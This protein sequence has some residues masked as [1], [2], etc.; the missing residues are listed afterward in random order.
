MF[1]L[2][3]Q[4]KQYLTD[5]MGKVSR[6]F[7]LVVAQ[8]EEPLNLFLATAYL[9]CRVA[10]NIEDSLRPISWQQQRFNEFGRL[11]QEPALA[12]EI[13]ARWS[14]E[15]W[16]GLSADEQSMMGLG[17][18]ARLWK[19]YGALPGPTQ[20]SIFD[21]VSVMAQGMAQLEGADAPPLTMRLNGIRLLVS[22]Q[23][24]NRYCYFVAGTVGY[25]STELVVAH[26]EIGEGVAQRLYESCEACGRGLQ[27][28][29]IIKDFAEDLQRQVCY[30]PATWL[31]EANY[32]PLALEGAPRSWKQRV[33][34][35]AQRELHQ[36]LD[37]VLT[38]P[39]NAVGYRKASLMC[40]LPGLH[41]LLMAAQKVD[42]LFTSQ[43]YVK[44]SRANMMQCL[45]ESQ[46]IWMDNDAISERCLALEQA[47]TTSL[48]RTPAFPWPDAAPV[49]VA[50]EPQEQVEA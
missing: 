31:K 22:E 49:A 26:Y 7:A 33:I 9:I 19:I 18:G 1:T 11:L 10:D 47:I 12:P 39:T 37:H 14:R 6:S 42:S 27:K 50:P 30:L 21:W 4:D 32:A 36:A 13:L 46:S 43:H 38:L 28:T 24:Y 23:D 41:T 34:Q 5:S 45:L 16:P 15:K 2:A 35:D 17:G 20:Q 3:P 25:L 48:G 8:L 44:I 40:L 29:N